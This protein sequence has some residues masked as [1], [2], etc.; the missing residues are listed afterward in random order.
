MDM[1][2]FYTTK[3]WFGEKKWESEYVFVVLLTRKKARAKE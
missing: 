2:N 3:N 1:K